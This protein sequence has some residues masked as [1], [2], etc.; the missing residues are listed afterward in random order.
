MHILARY[1]IWTSRSNDSVRPN[2]RQKAAPYRRSWSDKRA[3][4]HNLLA[5]ALQSARYRRLIRDISGWIESGPWSTRRGKQAAKERAAT[6]A[7]YGVDKLARWQEKLL[8]KS[9]KLS[10]M[11]AE[12][13][14][15]GCVC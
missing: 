6:I 14:H 8:T 5:R 7:D 1:A 3:D 15:R 10:K 11:D 13:R 12:K 4:S 2:R 9:R